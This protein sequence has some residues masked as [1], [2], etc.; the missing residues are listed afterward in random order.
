M[1]PNI[2]ISATLSVFFMFKNGVTFIFG[3]FNYL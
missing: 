2:S 3:K 1:S